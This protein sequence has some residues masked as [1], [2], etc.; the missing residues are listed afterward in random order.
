[1]TNCSIKKWWQRSVALLLLML[2][3]SLY[4]GPIYSA[5]W[6]KGSQV[7]LLYGDQH[8]THKLFEG[9]DVVLANQFVEALSKSN[10]DILLLIEDLYN[11]PFSGEIFNQCRTLFPIDIFTS[12]MPLLSE[13]TRRNYDQSWLSHV[14]VKTVDMRSEFTLCEYMFKT[15]E[16]FREHLD[17]ILF[18]QTYGK[19]IPEVIVQTTNVLT[20]LVNKF[21][22]ALP[23]KRIKT[24]INS[25]IMLIDDWLKKTNHNAA[26][27]VL[28]QVK[29][30]FL[31]RQKTLFNVLIAYGF[32][33]QEVDD[34]SLKDILYNTDFTTYCEDEVKWKRYQML[35]SLFVIELM[36]EYFSPIVE[37][38]ALWHIASA[39][40]YKKI[41]VIMGA[42]H[43]FK[44]ESHL[45]ELGY[46]YITGE[47]PECRKL[48]QRLWKK[49]F[50]GF[51]DNV[52][53]NEMFIGRKED[54]FALL[55]NQT[56][57]N[58]AYRQS[59]GAEVVVVPVADFY[60][61]KVALVSPKS[62]TW[63]D[64]H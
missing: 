8:D 53:N 17:T 51:A 10:D 47:H 31:D 28:S 7:V 33:P 54:T 13:Y 16:N 3:Q 22:N 41:V 42:D 57:H 15:Y 40:S 23:E 20:D 1:M 62:F 2:S 11:P 25:P 4:A 36:D 56:M 46:E 55:L 35:V 48:H 6:Q 43:V 60:H 58:W 63:I 59:P 14:H 24:I 9:K 50:A 34:L 52:K 39:D 19:V 45:K 29:N 12:F 49:I 64:E 61:T 27:M 32:S 38:C 18:C 37:T 26:K 30:L 44:L 5:K 21:Y